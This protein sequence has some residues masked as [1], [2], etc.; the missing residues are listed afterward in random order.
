MHI[1]VHE[2][3]QNVDPALRRSATLRFFEHLVA[4][5]GSTLRIEPIL[6]LASPA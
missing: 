2:V 4:F 1:S 5:F 6:L 3:F